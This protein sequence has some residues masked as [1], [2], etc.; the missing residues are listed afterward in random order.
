MIGVVLAGGSSRRFG[1]DKLFYPIR[2]RPLVLNVVEN[3]RRA[4]GVLKVVV[5]ASA[6]NVGR[7][8]E[9]GLDTIIDN[10][11]IGP[12]GGIYIALRAFGTIIAVAGDMPFVTSSA[13]E[14]LIRLCKDEYE[15]DACVPS[16]RCGYLEPLFSIYRASALKVVE[17]CISEGSLSLHKVLRSMRT[18]RVPVEEIV[19]DP[20]KTFLNVNTFEDLKR[21]RELL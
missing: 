9:L 6:K 16:W 5:V 13:V 18:L 4:R 21:V 2:G 14:K 15:Y 1:I 3:L 20:E 17:Q 8:D 11:C 10:L 7:F 19:D 12:L